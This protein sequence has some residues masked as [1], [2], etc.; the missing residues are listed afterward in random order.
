MENPSMGAVLRAIEIPDV[1]G[2]TLFADMAAA[3]DGLPEGI[4]KDID[5][6]VA[7][8]D[9]K[10]TPDEKDYDAEWYQSHTSKF[11]SAEHPIVTI[12]PESGRKILYVNSRYTTAIKGL[13]KQTGAELL[14]YLCSRA[15]IPEYQVRFKWRVGSI[16][17]WD[18]R[19]TQHYASADYGSAAR[20]MERIG[21]AEQAHR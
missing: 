16:A 8:H 3:Y 7:V 17:F 18:N 2:D 20:R 10:K 19:S 12:H 4:K 5:G 11:P 15:A 13:S 9:G 1:G 14:T 21:I 6:L